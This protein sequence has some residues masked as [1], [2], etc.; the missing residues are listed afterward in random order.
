MKKR[1]YDITLESVCRTDS[2]LAI[3]YKSPPYGIME[4][5]ACV[6]ESILAGHSCC[7]WDYHTVLKRS[8]CSEDPGES[9]SDTITCVISKIPQQI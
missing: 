2:D 3:A 7:S 5:T 6:A 1:G 4:I 8:S 9:R